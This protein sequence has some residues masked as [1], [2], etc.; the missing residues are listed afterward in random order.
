MAGHNRCILAIFSPQIWWASCRS[1]AGRHAKMPARWRSRVRLASCLIETSALVDSRSTGSRNPRPLAPALEAQLRLRRKQPRQGSLRRADV[2]RQCLDFM[3]GGGIAEHDFGGVAAARLL[4]QRDERRGVFGA[5]QFEHRKPDQERGPLRV[6]A[7]RRTTPGSIH[8]TSGDTRTT[9]SE[10]RFELCFSRPSHFEIEIQRA[11]LD[12]GEHI[13]RVPKPRRHPYRAIRRHQPASP[14][15]R[16]L[17]RAFGLRT[18]V[19]P[20]DACGCRAAHLSCSGSQSDERRRR[21][22]TGDPGSQQLAFRRYSLAASRQLK[23][24]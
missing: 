24:V 10:S 12:V 11:H 20:R 22:R 9:N 19:A 17:H 14:G 2:A 16:H 3:Q 23:T 4:R 18:P 8:A 13:D 6:L 1:P 7:H 15:G 21:S 5:M